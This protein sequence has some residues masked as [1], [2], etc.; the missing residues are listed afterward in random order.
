MINRELVEATVNSY[1]GVDEYGQQLAELTGTR[2][3][4]VA[5]GIYTHTA[6]NDIRYQDVKYYGLTQDKAITDK[7]YLV[8]GDKTYKVLYVN[9]TTRWTQL[10]LC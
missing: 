2:T 3:I 7:D 9:S 1:G 8:V 6:T 10:Y 5:I 4:T